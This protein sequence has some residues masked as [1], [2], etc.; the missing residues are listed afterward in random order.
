[1]YYFVLHI[2]CLHVFIYHETIDVNLTVVSLF[3]GNV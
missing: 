1:M 3:I 2:F